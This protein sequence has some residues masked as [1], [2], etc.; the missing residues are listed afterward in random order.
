MAVLGGHS[1]RYK[2][3]FPV[4]LQIERCTRPTDRKLT[5]YRKKIKL[6]RTLTIEMLRV[7]MLTT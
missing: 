5:K 2:E 1:Q 3:I 6:K 4:E 7:A